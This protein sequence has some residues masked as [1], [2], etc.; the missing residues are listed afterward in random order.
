MP[1]RLACLRQSICLNGAFVEVGSVSAGTLG[2]L[3]VGFDGQPFFL[4]LGGYEVDPAFKRVN[5]CFSIDF[6]D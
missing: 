6:I 5:A 2:E 1:K 4:S 3:N